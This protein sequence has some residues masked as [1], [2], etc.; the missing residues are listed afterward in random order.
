MFQMV[1][2]LT[3][4]FRIVSL[5]IYIYTHNILQLGWGAEQSERE[6]AHVSP[7]PPQN[8]NHWKEKLHIKFAFSNSLDE[9]IM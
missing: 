7:P 4:I 2:N 1:V 5:S 8:R 9:K 6:P 3:S